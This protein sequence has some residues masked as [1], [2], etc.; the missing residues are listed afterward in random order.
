MEYTPKNPEAT[1][2]SALKERDISVKRGE[3]EAAFSDEARKAENA[4]W[5][6]EHVS[7]DTSLTREELALYGSSFSLDLLGLA[8]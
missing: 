8:N 7:Y 1:L 5:V 2:I 3:I 6:S 4:K